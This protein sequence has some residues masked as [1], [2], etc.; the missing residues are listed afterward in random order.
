MGDT[1]RLGMSDTFIIDDDVSQWFIYWFFPFFVGSSSFVVKVIYDLHFS[2]RLMHSLFG[3]GLCKKYF[4]IFYL[5]VH[6]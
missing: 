5:F 6:S 1:A 4:K 3:I 2:Q